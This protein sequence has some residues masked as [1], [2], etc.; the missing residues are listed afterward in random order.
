MI[1]S[2]KDNLP[3]FDF[4]HLSYLQIGLTIGFSCIFHKDLFRI[5]RQLIDLI[6]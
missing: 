1:D 5:G 3:V 4:Q 2:G 6:A